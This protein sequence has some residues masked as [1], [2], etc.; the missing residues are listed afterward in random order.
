M[1]GWYAVDLDATLAHYTGWRDGRI[2]HPIP[3]MADKDFST[4]EIWD[5]RAVQ[6]EPNTGRRVDGL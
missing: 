1:S 6:V 5:D 3:A 4:I 2:G